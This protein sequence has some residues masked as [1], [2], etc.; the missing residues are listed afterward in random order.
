MKDLHAG[1]QTVL[2][3]IR[4]RFWPLS[5]RRCVRDVLQKCV[6]CFRVKPRDI[7]QKMGNL[8]RSR[9][10]PSFLFMI[11][12]VA[13][14]TYTIKDSKLS[15]KRLIKAYIC[16]F[17]CFSAKAVHIEV[18]SDLSAEGFL[19]VFKRFVSRRG[20][21]SEIYSDNAGNFVSANR[22][23]SEIVV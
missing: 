23:L 8:P 12:G 21:C 11:C 15:N 20:L 1:P 3:N 17:I 14:G 5:R 19:N 16:I 13:A 10:T 18:V 9:V 7:V 4:K 2:S 6:I 22:Q